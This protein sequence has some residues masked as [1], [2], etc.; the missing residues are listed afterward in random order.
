[1]NGNSLELLD[2]DVNSV[3]S[4]DRREVILLERT[5]SGRPAKFESGGATSPVVGRATVVCGPHGEKMLPTYVKKT[6]PRAM[7]DHALFVVFAG[8]L[9]VEIE[10]VKDVFNISVLKI[11]SI[12][13]KENKFEAVVVKI[14]ECDGGEWDKEHLRDRF[15]DAIEAAKKKSGCYHCREVHY[16]LEMH[17][18]D[19]NLL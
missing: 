17:V 19:A 10:R 15:A 7:G 9:I 6:G 1:M 18:R 11:K 8:T 4:E 3:K 2:E 12:I 13:E 5:R 16:G 14:L